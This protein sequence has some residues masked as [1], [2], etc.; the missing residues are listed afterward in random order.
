MTKMRQA[1]DA[2]Q[3]KNEEEAR[4]KRQAEERVA[5]K[6]EQMKKLQVVGGLF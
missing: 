5:E 2:L 6:S 3:S 1:L 4:G